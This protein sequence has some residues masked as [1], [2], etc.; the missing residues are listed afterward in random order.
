MEF[1]EFRPA[2]SHPMN[3]KA[4]CEDTRDAPAWHEIRLE[5]TMP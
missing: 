2:Q 1:R 3:E 4:V 5:D